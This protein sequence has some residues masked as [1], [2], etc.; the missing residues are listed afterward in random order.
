MKMIKILLVVIGL[1]SCTFLSKEKQTPEPV[2]IDVRTST[3]YE[4]GHVKDS[5]NIP[6]REIKDRITE[7]TADRETE[8]HLYC[9]SGGRAELARKDL[10]ELGYTNVTNDGGYR[11][12]IAEQKASDP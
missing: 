10:L 7:I 8:I 1:A 3:E 12:I 2:W 11:D 6:H 9:G 5:V 4:S